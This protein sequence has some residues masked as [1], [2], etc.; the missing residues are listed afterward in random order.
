MAEEERVEPE[1]LDKI[2]AARRQLVTAIQLHFSGGDPV[3]VYSLGSNAWEIID[4]LCTL[5]GVPSFSDDTRGHVQDSK[6]LKRD[7]VNS[8][9]RNFFKHADRDPN[10]TLEGFTDVA[11]DHILYLAAEDYLRLRRRAPIEIQVYQLWY[12]A[13]YP[14]K[15]RPAALIRVLE[16]IERELPEILVRSRPEQISMG[17]IFLLNSLSDPALASDPQT[18]P[19]R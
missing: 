6:D 2:G 18:E 14:G 13:L 4:S 19:S 12:L 9:Y 16:P 5:A 1:V 15:I 7:F 3:S 11:C 8:P 10:A 17:R